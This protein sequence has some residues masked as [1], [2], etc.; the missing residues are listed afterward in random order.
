MFNEAPLYYILITAI[1]VCFLALLGLHFYFRVRVFRAYKKLVQNR[2]DIDLKAF[3]NNR[4][5]AEEVIPK[6]PGFE[7]DIWA[8]V[9][10]LK[11]AMT[12]ASV[13]LVLIIILGA[14]LMYYRS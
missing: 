6:Y 5:L 14:T 8:F 7:K 2:I 1:I 4:K 13:F 10:N 3:F 11:R 9:L 12:L